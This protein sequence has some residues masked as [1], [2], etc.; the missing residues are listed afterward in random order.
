MTHDESSRVSKDKT[1][2]T[3]TA[4]YDSLNAIIQLERSGGYWV[5]LWEFRCGVWV[6]T[7]HIHSQGILKYFI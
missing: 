2:K 4:A 7:R 5:K 6:V 3:E 1:I